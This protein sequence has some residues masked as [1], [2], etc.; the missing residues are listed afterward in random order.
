[1]V[2]Q[3]FIS[4]ELLG[5]WSCAFLAR[6]TKIPFVC[7]GSMYILVPLKAVMT[8]RVRHW[9]TRGEAARL[10]PHH[11]IEIKKNV[12]TMVSNVLRNSPVSRYKPLESS[13][14]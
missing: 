5:R 10:L 2:I 11:Q 12:D 1:M 3:S 13:D 6:E 8:K 14:N 7:R 4:T 9:R